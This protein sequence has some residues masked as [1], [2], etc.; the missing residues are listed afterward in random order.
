[1]INKLCLA[2]KNAIIT[3]LLLLFSFYN[4]AQEAVNPYNPE[5]KMELKK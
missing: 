1:M 5:T 3:S 4:F 2:K